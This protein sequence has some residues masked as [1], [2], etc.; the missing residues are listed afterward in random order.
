[1]NHPPMPLYVSTMFPSI[2][3]PY[4]P[5]RC[6]SL[7]YSHLFLPIHHHNPTPSAPLLGDIS[8]TPTPF[9]PFEATAIPNHRVLHHLISFKTPTSD[10]I[11]VR[12]AD[13]NLREK[14]VEQSRPTLIQRSV[15]GKPATTGMFDRLQTSC[16]G[17]MSYSRPS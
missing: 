15:H 16:E 13:I 11:K 9:L 14:G 5:E 17:A 8:T 6:T 10:G 4:D 7:E 2:F 1:M 12:I 3:L